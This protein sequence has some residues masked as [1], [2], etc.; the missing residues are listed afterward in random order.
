MSEE[1]RNRLLA[2]VKRDGRPWKR[3][4]RDAGQNETYV[5]DLLDPQPARVAA[6]PRIDTL[7]RLCQTLNI[8]LAEILDPDYRPGIAV[9]VVGYVSGGESWHPFDDHA[10]GGGLD[11]ISFDMSDA[12]AIAIRVRG[13]SMAPVYRDGDDLICSRVMGTD[14]RRA[15][16]RDC[17]IMTA[18]GAAFVKILLAGSQPNMF[19]LRSYNH[20]YDDIEDVELAWAAP[21]SWIHRRG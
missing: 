10:K 17:A 18:D 21:I 2:A 7:G 13:T 16:N 6:T 3:L 20:A 12:D 11:F 19:R 9:P 4:S 8:S 15:L 1:W 5:R 14:I